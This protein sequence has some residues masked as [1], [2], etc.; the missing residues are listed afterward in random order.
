MF[1]N[2]FRPVVSGSATQ[3]EALARELVRLGHKPFVITALVRKDCQEYE[4]IEGVPIYRLPAFR[5]PGMGIAL[6]FPWLSY[7]FT[8]ANLRRI[9]VILRKHRP[10]LLHLHNH[11]FDLAFAAVRMKHRFKLPLLV[12]IHTMI[13]HVKP[14]YNLVLYPADRVFLR[15]TVIKQADTV[16]C[17][18]YNIKT[19]VDDAFPG[20]NAKVCPYG[21]EV[22]PPADP[23]LVEE[24]RRKHNLAGKRVILSLGHVHELRHRRELV[25]IL[26][27]IRKAH[28][29]AVV[30]IVGAETIDSPRKLAQTLKVSDAVI[31]AGYAP[32]ELVSAYLALADLEMHLFCQD[33]IE[34]TSLGIA[35]MEAMGAGKAVLVAANENTYGP[36][37]LRNGEDVV[38]V[39]PAKPQ[40][41]ART[42]IELLGDKDR[43]DRVGAAARRFVLDHLS[44]E[45]ISSQTVDLYRAALQSGRGTCP[46]PKLTGSA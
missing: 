3:S 9:D 4:V 37:V 20:S 16:I 41:M 42:I 10:D 8:P 29:N 46:A 27:D 24:L 40:E 13:R 31:F 6:N 1:S 44:W 5:L 32:H 18:D 25:G 34:R 12:T 23:N 19:Y 33:A 11:M 30:L 43:R 36:G 45:V 2:L 22:P 15:H 7:T 21:V 28:P 26:P 38:F 14:I 39:D 35:S 17:P